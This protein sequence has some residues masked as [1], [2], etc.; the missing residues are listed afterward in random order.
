MRFVEK[1]K[2][3]SGKKLILVFIALIVCTCMVAAQDKTQA[4]PETSIKHV[5]VK[6]TS[7][8]SGKEMYTAY[9]AVCHGTDGKGGGPAASALKVPPTNLTVLSKNNGGKYPALK[10]TSAIH[11]ESATPAHGSKEMPVWGSLFFNMSGGHESEVQQRTANL[12]KY[13]ETLQAK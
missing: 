2:I 9:C 7:P 4:Q 11:G 1:E 12:A 8:V 6:A 10:V 13:I 5:P 3:M